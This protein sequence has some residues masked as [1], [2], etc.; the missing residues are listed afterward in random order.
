MSRINISRASTL[1]WSALF[2]LSMC[3]LSLS[4]QD[5]TSSPYTR[6][7]YGQLADA[8]PVTYKGMAGVSIGLESKRTINFANPAAYATSDS[9]AFLMD[10]GASMNWSRYSDGSVSKSALLGNL[11]Y[12]A[13]QFPVFRD[14][15]V[16]SAGIVPFSLAGYGMQRLTSVTNDDSSQ[17]TLQ[18]EYS[19]EGS[20]QSLYVGLGAKTFGGLTI[21]ANLRYVFGAVTHTELLVPNSTLLK[22]TRT[23]NRLGVEGMALDFG[24]QYRIDLNKTDNIIVGATF[25][26]A[27]SIAPR[28]TSIIDNNY[29]SVLQPDITEKTLSPSTQLPMKMGFGLSWNKADKL[30]VGSDVQI[31]KWG[32][33]SNI[34]TNDGLEL[35]D[36]YKVALGAEYRKD[37]YS[38]RYADR[39]I[40]RG[41]LNY[42]TSYTDISPVGKLD[43]VTASLGVGLPVNVYNE[44]TSYVNLSLEYVKGLPSTPKVF[45]EDVLRLS[46][47]INFN[48]IW[49]RKLKIY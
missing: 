31:T 37:M 3:P 10:F 39:I 1:L 25:S 23:I 29:G 6:F 16:F 28:L 43:R 12:F 40:Y 48:E 21:G 35:K 49:F 14:R 33:V 11:D 17:Y 46:L 9:L 38:R 19:G 42:T 13:I 7:G 44:R 24:A 4:G 27:M 30:I 15:L 18:Q 41:G 36:V 47:S 2:A 34:F 20:I 32:S 8:V 22:K 26:P 45:N 5:I